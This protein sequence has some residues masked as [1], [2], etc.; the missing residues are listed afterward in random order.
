MAGR[1]L[2][3][4]SALAIVSFLLTPSHGSSMRENDTALICFEGDCYPRY[5][6]AEAEFKEVREGQIVDEGLFIRINLS[7]GKKEARLLTS[8][9]APTSQ[10]LTAVV[11]PDWAYSLQ[12]D[13]IAKYFT[14]LGS[15]STTE[16]L[17]QLDLLEEECHELD[18]AERL[19][20][21]QATF[22]SIKGLLRHSYALVRSKAA[23]VLGGALNNNPTV[24]QRAFEHYHL[25]E[26]LSSALQV[27]DDMTCMKHELFALGALLRG[28][29]EG[30]QRFQESAFAL[31]KV[32]AR[33]A[34]EARRQDILA[35]IRTL[36]EDM[37][38][39]EQFP[40]DD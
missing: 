9:E 11:V 31:M 10:D 24:R 29:S 35:R 8:D 17:E 36:S 18:F 19:S 33:K 26:A 23:L 25:Y 32:V 1:L 34:T 13:A 4:F 21:S 20:R 15:A 37:A 30:T 12:D 3:I 27:E 7:T 39:T 5:F 2:R 28:S 14:A 38:D 16:V 6:V 40:E 22:N